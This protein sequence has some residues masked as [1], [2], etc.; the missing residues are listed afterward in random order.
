VSQEL[1][2]KILNYIALLENTNEQLVKTLKR[3]V[4]LLTEFK[5]S[6]H[7]P[8]GWQ[9]RGCPGSCLLHTT[10]QLLYSTTKIKIIGF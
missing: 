2:Q 8:Q 9:G 4:E 5:S 3:C 1:D 7:D 10:I 6:V